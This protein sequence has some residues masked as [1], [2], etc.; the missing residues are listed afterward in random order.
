[1]QANSKNNNC[2]CAAPQ[3][4]INPAY[5]AAELAYALNQAAVTALVLAR[6][7][8]GSRE[9]IDIVDSVVAQ[10]QLRHRI[11]LA[12]EAPEGEPGLLRCAV[13]CCAVLC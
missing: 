2:C 9:F 12:D 7:L 8:K 6:G 13:L 5:R 4:N 10:T 1:M 3:V 11:L